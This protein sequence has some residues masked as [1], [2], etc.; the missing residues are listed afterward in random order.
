MIGMTMATLRPHMLALGAREGS[1]SQV[2]DLPLGTP[3]AEAWSTCV[4]VNW[5]LW[6][7]AHAGVRQELLVLVASDV[8]QTVLPIW[9][10]VYPADRRLISAIGLLERWA[11]GGAS[12]VDLAA[13]I[14]SIANAKMLDLGLVCAAQSVAKSVVHALGAALPGS[15]DHVWVSAYSAVLHADAAVVARDGGDVGGLDVR[16]RANMVRARI[17]WQTVEDALVWKGFSR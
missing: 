10:S 16:S 9:D 8:A 5:L 17:D 12:S 4:S 15:E 11:I 14:A 6:M 13:A 3:A 2:W 7:A 1:V